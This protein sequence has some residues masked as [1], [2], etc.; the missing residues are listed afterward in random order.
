MNAQKGF[1]AQGGSHRVLLTF[2]FPFS[3]IF[4]NLEG[5]TCWTRK[6]IKFWIERIIVNSAEELSFRGTQF[7]SLIS[8]QEEPTVEKGEDYTS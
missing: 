1:P 8:I 3:V 7:H 6:G 5:N 2:D 4:L